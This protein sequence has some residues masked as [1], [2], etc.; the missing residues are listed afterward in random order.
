MVEVVMM[1]AIQKL[2]DCQMSRKAQP[3]R[4]VGVLETFRK[5]Y[6]DKMTFR[7][8]YIIKGDGTVCEWV[9]NERFLCDLHARNPLASS[10]MAAT[11]TGSASGKSS[12]TS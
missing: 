3:H 7:Y 6:L 11:G 4:V 12:N 1:M 8:I 5:N 10:G 2:Q 9:M